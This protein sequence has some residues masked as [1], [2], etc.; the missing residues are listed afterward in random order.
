MGF[1]SDALD[2]IIPNEI[3]DF[4]GSTGIGRRLHDITGIKELDPHGMYEDEYNASVAANEAAR[5]EYLES[6]ASKNAMEQMRGQR[7]WKKA[8]AA[9]NKSLKQLKMKYL[10]K[11]HEGE[12]QFKTDISN[13]QQQEKSSSVPKP[14]FAKQYVQSRQ[15]A[16]SSGMMGNLKAR[17]LPYT[18]PQNEERPI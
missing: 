17:G 3:K 5:A 11:K 6:Q 14:S 4:I 7:E 8:Q 10:I 1:V 16:A 18:P 2:K 12:K 15:R 9:H 13:I